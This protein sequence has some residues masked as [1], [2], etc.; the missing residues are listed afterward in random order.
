[1]IGSR[2][3]GSSGGKGSD[4]GLPYVLSISVIVLDGGVQRVVVMHED[5]GPQTSRTD[6][7]QT[8]EYCV[9]GDCVLPEPRASSIALE[10]MP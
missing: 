6:A 8:S 10:R 1:M 2:S 4:I 3:S 5:Y 9:E 7:K